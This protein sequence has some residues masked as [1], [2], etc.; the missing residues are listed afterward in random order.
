MYHVISDSDILEKWIWMVPFSKIKTAVY[1][2]VVLTLSKDEHL[3]LV[4]VNVKIEI[5]IFGV[6]FARVK[7][8]FTFIWFLEYVCNV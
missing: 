6:K 2:Q 1:F 3:I 5:I 7:R 8:T 4:N